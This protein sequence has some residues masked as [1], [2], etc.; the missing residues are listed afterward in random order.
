MA[1]FTSILPFWRSL[2]SPVTGSLLPAL[3]G[4]AC[5]RQDFGTNSSF[6][7]QFGSLMDDPVTG[8]PAL[9]SS[10]NCRA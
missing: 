5:N 4:C 10:K 2:F 3:A 9:F 6:E 7:L 8:R 1:S